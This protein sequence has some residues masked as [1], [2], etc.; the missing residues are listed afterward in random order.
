M[1]MSKV[2]LAV[3]L[4]STAGVLAS[5]GGGA[6]EYSLGVGYVTSWSGTQMDT[7]VVSAVFDKDGKVV[8]A[9][10][11]V[12]QTKFAI[13]EGAVTKTAGDKSKQELGTDYNMKKFGNSI[14]E[15]Y[16]QIN[17]W[18]TYTVGKTAAEVA[19][20]EKLTEEKD[21]H[22]VGSPVSM[23]G[24]TI[25]VTAFEQALTNAY[26]NKTAS[27]KSKVAPKAGVG[28][29][30]GGLWDGE[31]SL[32]ISGAAVAD[33]S[34][35]ASYTDCLTWLPS[36]KEEAITIKTESYGSEN[37]YSKNAKEGQAICSKRDLG[38]KYGM[39]KDD[40][41]EY[42]VQMASLD[43]FVTGKTVAELGSFTCE[44]KDETVAGV[45]INKVGLVNAAK[46]A[47]AYSQKTVITDKP[48]Q[49]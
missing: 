6:K 5:C 16:E 32:Y 22:H 24:V 27:F 43:A 41:K 48:V 28:M 30:D 29:V 33:S 46:E 2:L 35:V 23:T 17:S 34:V 13:T 36:V 20:T 1:K 12:T 19:K 3:A 47:V 39:G 11:D 49:A 4:A 7:T 9:Q 31:V 8:S 14:A 15:V 42:D 37:K 18:T 44:E 25:T 10:A 26:A 21:G 38:T 45:T 40:I